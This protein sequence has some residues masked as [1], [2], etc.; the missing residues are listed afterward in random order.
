M[1]VLSRKVEERIQIGENI[2]LVVRRIAGNRVV[3]GIEAPSDVRIVR[4]ELTPM[5]P[6][7][8]HAGERLQAVA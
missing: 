8:A 1:L 3:L 4:S 5:D 2:L 7:L 6:I